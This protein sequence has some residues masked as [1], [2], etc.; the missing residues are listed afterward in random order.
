MSGK[1]NDTSK[2]DLSLVPAVAMEQMALA[3]MHGE[4]KYGRYNYCNGFESHRLVAAAL[5]HLT[6]YQSGENLDPESG[7]SHL[8]HAL[9]SIAM[10]LHTSQLGTN[11]DTRYSPGTRMQ[12]HAP[13]R[14]PGITENLYPNAYVTLD[15]HGLDGTPVVGKPK[16]VN[17][18]SVSEKWG[19]R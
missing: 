9:A 5:R 11:R 16:E 15:K 6:A 7:A 18:I 8:G 10:L 1:K 3:F 2:P 19:A 4:K 14:G 13:L 17:G 12:V